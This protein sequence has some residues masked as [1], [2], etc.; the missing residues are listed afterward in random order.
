VR[1]KILLSTKIPLG[2]D[3][4]EPGDYRRALERSLKIMDIDYIDFYHFWGIGRDALDNKI[5]KLNLLDEALKAKSEGL[6]RHISFSYHDDPA[7]MKY[8]IDRAG[9]FE[10]VLCQYNLLDRSNEEQIRYAASKGLGV[11]AMGPVAGGRLAAPSRMYKKLT[12][13]ESTATYELA[14]RFVLGNPD[15]ACALSGMESAEEL[16]KNLAVANLEDPMPPEERDKVVSAMEDVKKLSDLYCTGCKYCQPCPANIDIPKFFGIYTN[17]S[18]YGLSDYAKRDYEEARRHPEWSAMPSACTECGQ[19]EEK[20][21]QKLK[22][23]SLLK[24]VD[25]T[26]AEL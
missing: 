23:I 11:V 9:I 1:D 3:V 8:V 15:I 18:V 12:G 4:R 22:I 13:R 7:N 25:K 26:L 16:I 14:L 20:C 10:T 6:I 24:K 5:L 19:C 2:D 21:P 17:H